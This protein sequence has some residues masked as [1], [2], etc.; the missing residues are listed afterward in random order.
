ME[1]ERLQVARGEDQVGAERH[2]L[3][4]DLDVARAGD[5]GTAGE[6][7]L[8]IIF[9]VIGQEGLRYDAQDAPARHHHAAIVQ[10]PVARDGGAQQQHGAQIHAR[11]HH[12]GD[13]RLARLLL[14]GLQ[15]QI[16]DGI[17]GEVELGIDEQVRALVMPFACQCDRRLG[18]GRSIADGR[19]RRAGTDADQAMAVD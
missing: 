6:P 10:P 3:P 14:H 7:A 19:A 11:R 9:A 2:G 13:R 16:V 1:D 12:G 15:V 18:I 5:P 8:L 4:G 17:G